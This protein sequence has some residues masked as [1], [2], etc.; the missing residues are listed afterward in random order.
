[1]GMGGQGQ[2]LGHVR[3]GRCAATHGWRLEHVGGGS[4]VCEGVGTCAAVLRYTKRGC[5]ALLM[6]Q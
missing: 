2:R 4:D 6:R 1:M 3:G 5:R